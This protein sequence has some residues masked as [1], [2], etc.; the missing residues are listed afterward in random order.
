MQTGPTSLT[1]NGIRYELHPKMQHGRAVVEV[2]EVHIQPSTLLTMHERKAE[3][4]DVRLVINLEDLVQKKLRLK[5]ISGAW[6]HHSVGDNPV[7][8]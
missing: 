3:V 6:R 1:N 5:D 2:H 8:I 7:A 4:T